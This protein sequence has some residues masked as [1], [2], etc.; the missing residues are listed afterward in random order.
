VEAST[1]WANKYS[2]LLEQWH[3][4]KNG[5]KKI[6]DFA[7]FSHMKAWW[8]CSV[9]GGD[10]FIGIKNRT[11]NKSGC[12][13][14]TKRKLLVGFNDLATEHPEL[15]PEWHFNNALKPDQVI[16]GCTYRAMWICP[17]GHSYDAIVRNRVAGTGC[18]YC[19]GK[20]VIPG[21]TDLASCNPELVAEWHPTKNG[22]LTPQDVTFGSKR[23]VHWMCSKGHEWSTRVKDRTYSKKPTGCPYCHKAT[24]YPER[25]IMYFVKNVFPDAISS[26]KDKAKKISELDIFIPS[27]KIGIEYDGVR[28]HG[29]K[30]RDQIKN[31]ACRDA[32]IRL[33]R[34]RE[35]GC[36]SIRGEIINVDKNEK[37]LDEGI[38][39]LF[40]KLNVSETIDLSDYDRQKD[41]ILT[42]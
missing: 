37:S 30:K 6:E 41:K 29:N 8:H 15:V 11:A 14:C 10:W 39:K 20:K 25:K 36:P 2:G 32:K 42:G 18:P 35:L 1:R 34:I 33:I 4:T 12:P 40:E 27:L 23:V 19:D 28:F 13:Y 26:Y 16:S 5:E 24:S 38:I 9:C 3:P 31:K 22:N 7:E 17:N 21:E